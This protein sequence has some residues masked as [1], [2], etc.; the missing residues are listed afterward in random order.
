[1]VD[2]PPTAAT[3]LPGSRPDSRPRGVSG[4]ELNQEDLVLLCWFRN[5]MRFIGATSMCIRILNMAIRFRT[6]NPG[7]N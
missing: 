7:P 2:A 5:H 6:Q 3:A 4:R 1:M